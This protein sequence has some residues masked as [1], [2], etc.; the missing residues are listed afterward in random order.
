MCLSARELSLQP[1]RYVPRAKARTAPFASH[2]HVA[3]I[4]PMRFPCAFTT[5]RPTVRPVALVLGARNR[6]PSRAV[7]PCP[8]TLGSAG[9]WGNALVWAHSFDIAPSDHVKGD[10]AA[11]RR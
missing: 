9:D 5:D 3:P 6:Y 2:S 10:V 8:S 11:N 4:V 1:A 7:P